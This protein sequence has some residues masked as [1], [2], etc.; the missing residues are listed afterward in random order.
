MHPELIFMVISFV[1]ALPGSV[2]C[3]CCPTTF[4]M[5]LFSPL[6]FWLVVYIALCMYFLRGA[7]YIGF[8]LHCDAKFKICHI[9]ILLV[10]TTLPRHQA[11]KPCSQVSKEQHLQLQQVE[12]QWQ[13]PRPTRG[14][15]RHRGH[16]RQVAQ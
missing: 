12:C 13:R 8:T 5:C 2:L 11:F 15:Q 14:S 6:L 10:K 1:N 4:R 9:N 16:R 7:H 3:V